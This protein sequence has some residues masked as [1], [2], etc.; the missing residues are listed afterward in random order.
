MGLHLILCMCLLTALHI[1]MVN[2]V[3]ASAMG[4]QE[5]SLKIKLTKAQAI[6]FLDRCWYILKHKGIYM[7]N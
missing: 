1:M 3:T 6:R 7:Q 5:V 2:K 4:R